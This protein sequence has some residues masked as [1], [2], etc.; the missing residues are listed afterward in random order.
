MREG[1]SRYPWNESFPI[2]AVTGGLEFTCIFSAPRPICLRFSP[3]PISAREVT[4]CTARLGL[5]MSTRLPLCLLRPASI[6]RVNCLQTCRLDRLTKADLTSCNSASLRTKADALMDGKEADPKL[7]ALP[8][9]HQPSYQLDPSWRSHVR[10]A[11]GQDV[12]QILDKL[13]PLLVGKSGVGSQR[14]CLCLDGRGIRRSFHFKTFKQTWE[15]MQAVAEQCKS[16]RHHPEWWNV[17]S[18]NSFMSLIP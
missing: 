2:L 16:K 18:E 17:S 10:L 11:E 7:E 15:F 13:Q 3:W 4:A 6:R 5:S 9:D 12:T 8:G 1:S 14:W